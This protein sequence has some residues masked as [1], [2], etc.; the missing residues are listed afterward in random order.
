MQAISKVDT[1]ASEFSLSSSFRLFFHVFPRI[2]GY[3]A[4]ITIYE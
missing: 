4:S 3:E 2:L 1:M